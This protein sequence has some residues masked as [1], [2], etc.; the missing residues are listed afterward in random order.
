MV[1]P[2]RWLAQLTFAF[3]QGS[4]QALSA[5]LPTPV[6]VLHVGTV[7]AVR[8]LHPATNVF[9][10]QPTLARSASPSSRVLLAL[11]RMELHAQTYPDPPIAAP[12][13]LVIQALIAK[14]WH[15]AAATLASMVEPVEIRALATNALV[16]QDILGTD[17]KDSAFVLTTHV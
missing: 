14:F 12:A 9:V 13:L 4:L 3:A 2:A 7:A 16:C 8:Q 10:I 1:A 15:H 5:S 6:E 17:V 11:A